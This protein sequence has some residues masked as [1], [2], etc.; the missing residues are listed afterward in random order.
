MS[1]VKVNKVSPR[2]GTTV[3]I[4]DS[5]DTINLVGTLQNNGSPLTGDI[6]SVVAGTGLS[7][8][9]T[10]GVAT[11]NIEAAQP[12]ITSL[13][14]IATFRSTGIDDNATSTAITINSSEQ[15]AI[16]STNNG[17]GGAID[18]SVGNTSSAGGITLWSTTTAAHSI[19]FADGYTGTDRFRGYLEYR[20]NG[21]S[22]QFATSATER[23]RITSAGLVGIGTSS[24]SQKL[25]VS[26]TNNII[27]DNKTSTATGIAGI[28]LKGSN[29]DSYL[30]VFHLGPSFGGTTFGGVTGNN[31][32]LIEAQGVSSLVFTTQGGTPDIIFAPAR[33]A[34]MTIKNDGKIGIGTA[35]PAGKLDVAGTI[36]GDALQIDGDAV[37]QKASGDVSLTIQAN[38]NSS[39]REPALKLR[40][41]NSS[42]NP[43]IQYGDSTSYTGSI[44][45][46]N[47]DKSMQFGTNS[48]ERMRIDSSGNVLV[49]KTSSNTAT[50]GIELRAT[51][52]VTITRSGNTGL[53]VNRLSNDGSSV[54]FQKDGTNIG[55]IGNISAD[56]Y[57]TNSTAT[58][59]A[60]INLQN[61]LFVTPLKGGSRDTSSAVSFGNST[62]K[63]KDIYLGGG[64]FIGGT[65]DANKLDDY[66]EGTWSPAIDGNTITT[67]FYTKVGRMCVA[68]FG[69]ATSNIPELTNGSNFLITG[70][71]FGQIGSGWT[72][73]STPTASYA[74]ASASY[75]SFPLTG[76]QRNDGHIHI[77]N[78]SGQTKAANDP[79]NLCIVYQTN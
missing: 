29:T 75:H 12:T 67:G 79:L 57:I 15:V 24:P 54:K 14:T 4:G 27:Q 65:V 43:I 42:S 53:I 78:R 5:G 16:G 77:V 38:E 52:Q 9:A 23:M 30:K 1:E 25:E 51:D 39:G 8:G 31:Q 61:N 64:A 33:T 50:A 35:S 47:A 28:Q 17:V 49:G 45:Y 21:D 3:T 73:G 22:M 59:G 71:P 63:W 60:G 2:S 18:L 13:G 34:R 26:G 7:G 62:Y 11:L 6:S 44:Q 10:S 41:A 19:G 66:E 58:N 55:E 74:D 20:H 76:R 40:G 72:Y 68:T 69:D 32:S 48:S 37:I 46:E 56:F 70:L 36:I